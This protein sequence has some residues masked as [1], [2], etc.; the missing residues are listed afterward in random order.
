VCCG[1]VLLLTHRQDRSPTAHRVRESH[2]L[3]KLVT[4]EQALKF[5]IL[6]QK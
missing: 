3:S 5:N 2:R 4:T 1:G 6:P